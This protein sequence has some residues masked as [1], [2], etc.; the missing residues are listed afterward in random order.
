MENWQ[1]II[2]NAMK[3]LKRGCSMNE[4]GDDCDRCPFE[5]F[6]NRITPDEWDMEN[7]EDYTKL[8]TALFN[9]KNRKKLLTKHIIC[10]IIEPQRKERG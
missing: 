5:Y 8:Q 10:G 2:L 4:N 7:I 3:E 9:E 1:L 6:C